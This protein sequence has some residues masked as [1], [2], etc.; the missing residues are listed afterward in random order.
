MAESEATA[1]I[2]RYRDGDTPLTLP[3]LAVVG[4]KL[5]GIY[6][7]LQALP[8]LRYLPSLLWEA[9]GGGEWEWARLGY[10]L[11]YGSYFV[12][13]VI[14][15]G[16]SGWVVTRIMRIPPG[17][18]APLTGDEHFQAV[19]FSVAGVLLIAWGAAG[20]ASHVAY[21]AQV[22]AARNSGSTVS[23]AGYGGL[24]YPVVEAAAGAVLF[25][26]GRGLA[27][28]WH[29]MRYGGVRVKPAE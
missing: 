13:A 5:L 16:A 15:L 21:V 6:M 7:L 24:A 22:Q 9:R 18:V 23:D 20:I 26:R 25:L 10:L 8:Q 3:G 11:P 1:T 27:A 17:E 29:R 14:L 19:A 4:V 28:L 2:V 12:L